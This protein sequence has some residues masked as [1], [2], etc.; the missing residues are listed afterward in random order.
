VFAP[1]AP[2]PQIFSETEV[3]FSMITLE[4]P[5]VL[6]FQDADL[7]KI[8]FR[9][10]DLRKAEMTNVDWPE[11]VWPKKMPK[12]F[13]WLRSKRFG[14]YDEDSL[15]KGRTHS[16]PHIER[17]YRELKQNYE[18]RR[19][20]DR[21]GDFHYG[22]KEMRRKSPKTLARHWFPV[23]IYWWA[24]GYGERCLRP[25][26]WFVGLLLLSTFG[27]LYWGLEPKGSSSRMVM[28]NG[29][30]CLKSVHYSLRV[31]ILLKPDD[32]VP[33]GFGKFMNTVQSVFGP[34]L[35]GLFALALRQRLKR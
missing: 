3:D 33:V 20:Y 30:D 31:M 5:D 12:G 19:D 25:L 22:E 16:F 15:Q 29:W 21:A 13:G 8:T 27:Y 28:T 32:L 34:V 7:R 10:T 11:I 18:D 24:S 6:I 4:P 1:G 14:V 35:I 26:F 9:G 2:L 17:L 23:W